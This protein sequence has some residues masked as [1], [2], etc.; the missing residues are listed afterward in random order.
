MSIERISQLPIHIAKYTF[1]CAIFSQARIAPMK[2]IA[3]EIL[4]FQIKATPSRR[5]EKYYT[6]LI[7]VL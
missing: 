3:V 1:Q 2:D 7:A 5:F 6:Q 4:K